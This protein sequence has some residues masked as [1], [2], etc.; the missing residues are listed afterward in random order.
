MSW[1]LE[2]AGSQE[3]PVT[4]VTGANAGL[5][6]ETARALAESG[7]EVILA[8]RNADRPPRRVSWPAMIAAARP[9]APNPRPAA[10][11]STPWPDKA[12]TLLK[13]VQIN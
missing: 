12:P 4:I 11:W 5:G 13:H 2:Y 3:G 7:C 10:S 8:C 6:L 1:N 9:L